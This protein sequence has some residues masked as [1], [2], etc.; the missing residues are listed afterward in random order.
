[1]KYLELFF[2]RGKYAK[3]TGEDYRSYHRGG[4]DNKAVLD[5][6]TIIERDVVDPTIFNTISTTTS[7]LVTKDKVFI[8]PG[9]T[10]PRYK[11]RE[12]GKE[13]G[14]D[15]VRSLSKATKVIYCH[16]QVMDEMVEKQSCMGIE[17]KYL[18]LLFDQY[19]MDT[20]ELE[21]TTN[22]NII[23]DYEIYY[24]IKTLYN[25]IFASDDIDS[26]HF[27]VYSYTDSVYETLIN[28][29][30]S[31]T[32]VV[33]SDKD[34]MKQCNGSKPL[35]AESYK[36]LVSMFKTS[37]N[38]EIAMELLCN[39]DYDQSMV[40][41]LK[42]LSQFN[43]RAMPGTNHINYKSFRQYMTTH[44]G[45]DPSYYSGNIV[46]IIGKLADNGKLKREYLTE[47]KDEILDHVQRYGNNYIF[48]VGSV[49]MNETYKAKIVE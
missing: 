46:D 7:S 38:Q 14:F 6:V 17:I 45:I 18:K 48:T 12:T 42:L 10:I 1:M 8:M 36:R 4:N 11:I 49:Q 22:E 5:S 31:G 37:Q 23:I 28:E 43:F 19:N 13:I 2:D 9:V 32:K 25:N 26:S 3:I 27:Y 47:F 33:I 16:K 20:T 34:V 15:I 35:D 30:L 41:I 29:L 39:C 21:N 24:A 44:W 40:Y